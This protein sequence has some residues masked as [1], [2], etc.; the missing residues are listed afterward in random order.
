MLALKFNATCYLYKILDNG[1]QVLQNDI[2]AFFNDISIS[3]GSFRKCYV[4]VILDKN[5]KWV[6]T[7]DFPLGKCVVKKYKDKSFCRDKITDMVSSILARQCAVDFNKIVNI[8]NKLT[9]VLP[10]M[11]VDILNKELAYVEPFLDGK[12]IKFSDNCGKENFNFSAYIPAFSHYSWIKYKGRMV[13]NDIQGIFKDSK[14]YLT[15]PAVQSLELKYGNSDLGAM[16]IIS[17]LANHEHNDI[18]KNWKWVPKEFDP[19]LKLFKANSIRRTTFRFEVEKN[20]VKFTQL[21]ANLLKYVKF[22]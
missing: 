10:Y 3:E 14:Y 22:N 13:I 6:K 4:G 9:F 11:S 19:L 21:Y 18:C 16:G 15:D 20:L 2:I 17:F 12:F 5:K 8:P 1:K 7:N